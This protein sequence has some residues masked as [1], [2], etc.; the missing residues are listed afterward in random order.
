MFTFQAYPMP[1]LI[2]MSVDFFWPFVVSLVALCAILFVSLTHFRRFHR[3]I[4]S[5]QRQ[6]QFWVDHQDALMGSSTPVA[7]G[8]GMVALVGTTKESLTV[9]SDKIL[10]IASES[11]YV[12]V[13]YVDENGEKCKMLRQTM[14][15]MA[16][17]LAPHTHIVR[18][19]RAFM[20]NLRQIDHVESVGGSMMVSLKHSASHIPVSRAYISV[21]RQQV[22]S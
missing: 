5:L 1:S 22:V 17:T 16:V 15:E 10:Y 3:R 4:I 21:I 9:A 14:K 6:L 20:V 8:S 12:R 18:C 11:N 19:H 2:A 13:V 7:V